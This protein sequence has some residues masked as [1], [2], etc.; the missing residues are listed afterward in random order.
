LPNLVYIVN[1]ADE[2]AA[3]ELRSQS[4]VGQPWI[5]KRN[6]VVLLIALP[7][8]PFVSY[9]KLH[10][11]MILHTCTFYHPTHVTEVYYVYGNSRGG[12]G[13]PQNNHAQDLS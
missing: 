12:V 13:V 2:R 8:R 9:I 7:N 5:K 1:V 6:K 4:I 3:L 10:N 11:L